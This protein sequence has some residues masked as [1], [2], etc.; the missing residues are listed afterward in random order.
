[1]KDRIAQLD[2]KRDE[3]EAS[4]ARAA[5]DAAKCPARRACRSG[6]DES[7]NVEIRR[8]GAETRVCF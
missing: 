5:F 6:T 3:T 8:W 7:A 1:L 2:R 4:H